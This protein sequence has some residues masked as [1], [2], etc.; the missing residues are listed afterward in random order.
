MSDWAPIPRDVDWLKNLVAKLKVGGIWVMPAWGLMLQKVGERKLT[1]LKKRSEKAK[2]VAN[3]LSKLNV[4]I[5][6]P[7][8]NA[9]SEEEIIKRT[10]LVGKLAGIEVVEE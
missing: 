10:K 3:R 8:N 9:C 7:I 6:I 4:E 1:I 5:H 2:D